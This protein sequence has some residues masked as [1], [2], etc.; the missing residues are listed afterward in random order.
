MR[1]MSISIH[2]QIVAICVGINVEPDSDTTFLSFRVRFDF[3]R[4]N[5]DSLVQRPRPVR[6][7]IAFSNDMGSDQDSFATTE[8]RQRTAGAEAVCLNRKCAG[9][10][11]SA[12]Y[13]CRRR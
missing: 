7:H 9:K 10:E 5:V 12:E 1:R 3:L 13:K 6:L 11:D 8:P 2:L 4:F